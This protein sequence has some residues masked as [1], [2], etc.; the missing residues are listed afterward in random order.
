VRTISLNDLLRLPNDRVALRHVR[1][2]LSMRM[3]HFPN[4]SNYTI[5][6]VNVLFNPIT[7]H[8]SGNTALLHSCVDIPLSRQPSRPHADRAA[9]VAGVGNG[10]VAIACYPNLKALFVL[11]ALAGP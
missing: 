4:I 5:W 2:A 3:Y 8:H 11:A 7:G 10:M 9:G 1:R 6:C